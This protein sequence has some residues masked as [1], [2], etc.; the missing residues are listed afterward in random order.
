MAYIIRNLARLHG[1][2]A[3]LVQPGFDLLAAGRTAGHFVAG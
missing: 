3:L 1:R 2:L